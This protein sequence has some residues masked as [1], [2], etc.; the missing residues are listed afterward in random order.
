M[1]FL[2]KNPDFYPILAVCLDH[3]ALMVRAIWRCFAT[4]FLAGVSICLMNLRQRFPRCVRSNVSKAC[5]KRKKRGD[6]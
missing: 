2:K 3:S 6:A 5:G 1:I 4:G